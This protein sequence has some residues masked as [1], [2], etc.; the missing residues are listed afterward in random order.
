MSPDTDVQTIYII[1]QQKAM[2]RQRVPLTGHSLKKPFVIAVLITPI[3]HQT[4]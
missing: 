4:F 3:N 1:S 2:S